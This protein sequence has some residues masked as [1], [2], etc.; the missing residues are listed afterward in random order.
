[1]NRILRGII[2]GIILLAFTTTVSACPECRAQVRGDVYNQD[3]SGNLF[4]M[5]LPILVLV[6]IGIGLY[7]AD[8]ITERIKEGISK[9]QTK[10]D[11]AR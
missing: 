7:Y 6:A 9:W 8:E 3:F 5:L 11:V 2:D 10:E 1:M 4:I